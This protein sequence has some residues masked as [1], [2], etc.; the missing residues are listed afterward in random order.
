MGD[1]GGPGLLTFG[2]VDWQGDNGTMMWTCP[3]FYF[4]ALVR[5]EGPR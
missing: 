1:G 4:V 2:L 5:R 3:S